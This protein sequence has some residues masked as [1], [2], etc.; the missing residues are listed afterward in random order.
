GEPGQSE[1]K[2]KSAPLFRIDA[3]HAQNV[4]LYQAARQQ[5]H[6]PA[7][8]ANRTA[9]PVT[10][11]A[12]NIELK[13]RLNERKV[14]RPQA[15][16]NIPFKDAAQQGFHEVDEIRDGNI[17][18]HHHALKLIKRVL[19]RSVHLFVTEYPARSNH[20]QRRP[21]LSHPAHLNRRSVGTKQVAIG[22]P[23][24]IL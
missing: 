14:T 22:Q 4:R 18:I 16:A 8:L 5:L 19:V 3:A 21:Q 23:E 24:S 17:A 12:L 2:R 11:Q 6:P 15:H 7:L 20:A 1:A 9:G 10:D 13:A